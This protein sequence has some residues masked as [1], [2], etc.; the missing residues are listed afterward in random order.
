VC[1]DRCTYFLNDQPKM[2]EATGSDL[3]HAE[4]GLISVAARSK[5]CVCGRSHAGI[6]ALNPT[7]GPGNLSFVSI[8]YCQV[9]VSESG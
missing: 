3:S 8:V 5:E 1:C 6:E 9:E 4:A 2:R 7:G